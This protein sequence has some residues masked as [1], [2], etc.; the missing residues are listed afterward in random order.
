MKTM[1]LVLFGSYLWSK[2]IITLLAKIPRVSR[3]CITKKMTT[4]LG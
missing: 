4:K 2:S 3:V 1:V